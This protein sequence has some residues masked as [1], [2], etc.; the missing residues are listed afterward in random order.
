MIGLIALGGE[1]A[2]RRV[3]GSPWG[4][5]HV[6]RESSIAV[7]ESPTSIWSRL[8]PWGIPPRQSGVVYRR[9]GFPHVNR[10]SSIAVGDSPTSIGSRLSPWGIPPRQSGVVYRRGG[11]PRRSN[12]VQSLIIQYTIVN[13]R[14]YNPGIRD[15]RFGEKTEG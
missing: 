3:W 10:E 1:C 11:I 7:G 12:R 2:F 14:G 9:G 5:P 6:N 4:F 15:L 13:H 8:P